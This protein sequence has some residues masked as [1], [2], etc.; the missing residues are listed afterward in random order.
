MRHAVA[1]P[2]ALAVLAACKPPSSIDAVTAEP[3]EENLQ[4][5]AEMQAEREHLAPPAPSCG[6]DAWTTYGHDAARTSASDGCLWGPLRL[7]WSQTPQSFVDGTTLQGTATHAIADGDAVYVAGAL[8]PVPSVW[9]M[10]ADTGKTKWGYE[11]HTEAPRGGWPTVA[12]DRVYLVD[13][14][15]NWADVE[16]GRGRRAELD[17]WGES[18]SD[19]ERLFAENNWY[20]DGY[21]LYVSAFDM[22]LKLLWRRDYNALSKGYQVPDVGGLALAGGLLV[23]ASQHGVLHGTAL[24][25]FEPQSGERR[26]R[27]TTSPQSSPSIADGRVYT[28]ERLP[29]EKTDRLVARDLATGTLAWATEL[30]NARGPAPV[31][32]DH[33]VLVHASDGVVAFDAKSGDRVWT[34]GLPRTAPPVQSSTTLAAAMGSRTLVVVSGARVHVVRLD[35]G[36]E[37]WGDA[38]IP[39]AKKLEGPVIVGR[40]LYLVADARVVRLDGSDAQ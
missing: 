24:S 3:V 38:P 13:D 29:G 11:S 10:A 39:H 30:A 16:T 12:K 32:A 6:S 37:I 15:V 28:V 25:A 33:L 22:D 21:G 2:V 14:G 27:A 7:A 5:A 26:W 9:R 17:A 8:G 1:A 18:V 35:D 36:T 4:G 20:L 40:T 23:H 34:A 19:G 31:I